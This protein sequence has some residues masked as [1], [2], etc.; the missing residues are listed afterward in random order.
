MIRLIEAKYGKIIDKCDF[1]SVSGG[2]STIFKQQKMDSLRFQ[3]RRM[4]FITVL[5]FSFTV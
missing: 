2:G 4:N 5:D 1:I 3:K